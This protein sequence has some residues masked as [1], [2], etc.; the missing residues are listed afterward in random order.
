MEFHF[1]I[2]RADHRLSAARLARALGHKD[3][4]PG[5][6]REAREEQGEIGC[7]LNQAYLQRVSELSF[8]S[9]SGFLRGFMDLVYVHKG[10]LYGL[11]YKSNYLGDTYDDYHPGALQS[12]M[13]EHHYLLQALL[14]AVAIHRYGQARILGYDFERHFGGMHYL[15]VRG[16]HP[17]RPGRGVYFMRPS[18]DFL[19]GLSDVLAGPPLVLEAE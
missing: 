7:G 12:A 17:E 3:L 19:E 18:K 6:P 2:G 11:D 4:P 14:Y 5:A 13:E 15:F 1:P 10:R 16:M 9:W 8:S